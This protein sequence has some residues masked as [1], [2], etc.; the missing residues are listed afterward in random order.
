MLSSPADA[1]ASANSMTRSALTMRRPGFLDR[2]KGVVL[3][4]L[5]FA[6]ALL[7]WEW[8]VRFFEVKA[9]IAPAPSTVMGTLVS[10]FP[11]LM[12]NLGVTAFESIV[13]FVIGNV[14]A[15]LIAVA[16]VYRRWIDQAF[17]P[18]IVVINTIP[19][20]A[21]APILVLL[22]GNGF[23]PKIIIVA[24]ICFFPTL[25][26]MTRGLRDVSE[27]HLE[28]MKI[29]SASERE[30][31]VKLRFYGALPYLFSALKI[32]ASSAVV[33]AII[34]EWIG[35]TTGIGALIIQATYQYDSAMLYATIIVASAFSAI[36]FGLV[37]W[38]EKHMLKWRFDGTN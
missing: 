18:L 34:G 1:V 30:V 27:Q 5:V 20:V 23:V 28:L 15:C 8:A 7:L 32:T 37:A 26:N 12:Q 24:T 6:G 16:F 11:M 29:L 22:L 31:F 33:G 25:V 2:N 3:P 14:F 10:E 21:K 19:L 36:F 9:F 38:L 17:F 4:L 13:G 35:A